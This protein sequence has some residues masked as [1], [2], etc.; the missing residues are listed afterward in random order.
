MRFAV[1]ST[2]EFFVENIIVAQESQKEELETSLG[3]TLLDVSPLGLAIGDF[4][5]GQAWT[6]NICGEQVILPIIDDIDATEA[7][8]I[9]GDEEK[10]E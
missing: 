3:R 4:Y 9:S 2:N 6:R 5:N 10:E 1:L 8:V 7:I